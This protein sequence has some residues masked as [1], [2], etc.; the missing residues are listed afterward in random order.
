M[1]FFRIRKTVA[2]SEWDHPNMLMAE[3]REEKK[4]GKA[5]ADRLEKVVE[6]SKEGLMKDFFFHA[7]ARGEGDVAR[8]RE[9]VS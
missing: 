3:Q 5:M 1:L 9:D 4:K 6:G 8:A 7:V 2:Y